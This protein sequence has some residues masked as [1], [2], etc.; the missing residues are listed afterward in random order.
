VNEPRHVDPVDLLVFGPHPDDIEI[1]IGGTVAR[2]AADG[3]RVGM[4]DLTR[5]ELGTN[6]TP[7]DRLREAE[8]ARAVLRASWRVNLGWPDG[9]IDGTADQIRDAAELIRRARPRAIALP[10]WRDRHPDH[11]AA[12]HVLTRAAFKARLP[13]FP[14]E[15]EPWRS[16][17]W[18]CYYFINDAAPPSFVVD[19]SAHYEAKRRALACHRT[20]F[21]PSTPDAQATRLT[22]PLFSR[23]IE[24]RDMQFGARAGV[25]FAEG[26]IVR[27]PI[28][29]AD[30]FKTPRATPRS[31]P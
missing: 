31:S 11:V 26:F 5:G 3:C 23:L 12:S 8:D 21:M 17:E 15:G 16:G 29:R 1:G 13:R 14:A 2:H 10:Y 20:Q 6:G 24:S 28:A 19:V 30:L 18:L 22:S 9:A 7:D 4:C 25:D 27:E